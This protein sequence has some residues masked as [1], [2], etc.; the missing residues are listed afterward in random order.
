MAPLVDDAGCRASQLHRREAARAAIDHTSI[1]LSASW[2]P[3]PQMP[4]INGPAG[5]LIRGFAGLC[6]GLAAIWSWRCARS[7]AA[8]PDERARQPERLQAGSRSGGFSPTGSV[9]SQHEVDTVSCH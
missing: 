9:C 4:G 5:G 1:L 2:W 7:L 8:G 3:R 6:A